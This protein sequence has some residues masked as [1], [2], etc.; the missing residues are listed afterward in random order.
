[1]KFSLALIASAVTSVFATDPIAI[2]Q[3]SSINGRSKMGKHILSQARRVEEG[4]YEED[5]LFLAD[6]SLKFQ[7]C[8]HI[9]QWNAEADDEEDVRIMSKR[10][11]RFRLCPANTC[12]A[13]NAGGCDSGY[14][15]YIIDMNIFIAAWMENKQDVQEYQCEYYA[16]NV[17]GCDGDDQDDEDTCLYQC[18]GN[19]NMQYCDEYKNYQD[20]DGEQEEAF[21]VA[22]YMECANVDFEND[23]DGEDI[24][25][26]LG[27][28]CA[29][30]GGKIYLGMF[31]DDTCTTFADSNGGQTTYRT[32][33]GSSLPYSGETFIDSECYECV[34]PQDADEQNDG[35]QQDENE[36]KQICGEIYQQAGKCEEK[37]SGPMYPNENACTFM[38][39]IKITRTNG[40]IIRGS[41]TKNKVAGAFVGIFAVS[42]VLLG[43]YVYYLKTKLDRAK[44]NL[45][46]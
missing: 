22:E 5:Y 19:N 8:H 28:Y 30:Q 15:D 3:G 38:E 7:G 2:E 37:I 35:D 46:D 9:T 29:D 31:T 17:C 1:M 14:G 33:A 23:D 32:L 10:L 11:V 45:S 13:S 39:G 12:T 18:Y 24:E 34:E 21:E 42:F 27:P 26:F 16:E 44:I 20:D 41:S 4:Y 40:T 43:A 36:I 6:F 25:Y